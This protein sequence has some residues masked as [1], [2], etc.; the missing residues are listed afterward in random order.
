V[1]YSRKAARDLDR[2]LRVRQQK[3]YTASPK[4]WI[5]KSG[6]TT[7]SGIYQVVRDRAI[8]AGVGHVYRHLLRHT[9][10]H[11]WL[12]SEGVEGDLMRLAGW[13]LG[14]N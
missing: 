12:S 7:P 4:L 13:H 14:E 6:P 10:A 2:Y 11:M 5:G 1:P 8:Q 9:F 3:P